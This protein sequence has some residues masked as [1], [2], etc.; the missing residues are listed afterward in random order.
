MS[1]HTLQCVSTSNKVFQPRNGVSWI[2]AS[3][4]WWKEL[5]LAEMFRCS[6][7]EWVSSSAKWSS[8]F[9]YTAQD[10]SGI[11]SLAGQQCTKVLGSSVPSRSF[12]CTKLIQVFT[13]PPRWLRRLPA[14]PVGPKKR[15]LAVAFPRDLILFCP[16]FGVPLPWYGLD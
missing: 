3:M 6:S 8:A 5:E 10:L 12:S 15:P 2:N 1:K 4:C 7:G 13:D 11:F 9:I 16:H 14:A